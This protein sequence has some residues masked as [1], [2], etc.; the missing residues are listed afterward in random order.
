MKITTDPRKAFPRRFVPADAD[1]GRW[2]QIEPIGQALLA[3]RPDSPQALE[4]WLEDKSELATCIYE[5]RNRRYI[6]MT[7]QTDDPERERAYLTFVQE[8]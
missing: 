3:R 8:I 7:S 1:M 5:E 4:Q 2:D 6:A